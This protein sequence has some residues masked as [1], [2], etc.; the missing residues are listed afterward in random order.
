MHAITSHSVYCCS[1]YFVALP[2]VLQCCQNE[3]VVVSVFDVGSSAIATRLVVEDAN[4]VVI[5]RTD[6]VDVKA[7]E[8]SVVVSEFFASL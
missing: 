2:K 5:N 6:T 4:G 7:G 1:D 8:T 3:R